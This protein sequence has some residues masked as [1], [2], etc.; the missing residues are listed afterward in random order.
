M[1]AAVTAFDP[2]HVL[3]VPRAAGA[4][5]IKA[6]YR[7]RAQ[8]AHPD[9]GGDPDTFIIIVKAFGLLADPESRRLYDEAGIVDEDG[10]RK[11]RQ[12]VRIVLADMFDA[13]VQSAV[14][15]GLPLGQV[16]FIAQMS[17]AVQKGQAEASRES[18]TFA[19]EIAALESL[20]KRIVR[21][22]GDANL[23]AERLD[24]QIAAKAAQQTTVRRRLLILETAAV[25]LGNYR[26]D[27]ELIGALEAAP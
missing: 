26:S 2:Y 13:A 9:R 15:T 14:A 24:A 17:M 18:A 20:R 4:S 12:E 1:R 10:V 25:E 19:G 3:G 5:A 6:A 16:D 23:F 7:R 22:D 27:V 11:H 21:A 8:Q